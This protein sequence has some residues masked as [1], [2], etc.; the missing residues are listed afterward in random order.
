MYPVSTTIWLSAHLSKVGELEKN[1]EVLQY[2]LIWP[3]IL[4]QG[5]KFMGQSLKEHSSFALRKMQFYAL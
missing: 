1:I 3:N 4:L 2:F 5:Y